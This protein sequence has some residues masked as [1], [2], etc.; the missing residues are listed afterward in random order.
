M[1]S[2]YVTSNILEVHKLESHPSPHK[3]VQIINYS[4]LLAI[5]KTLL[6]VR[7]TTQLIVAHARIMNY[8]VCP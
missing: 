5:P 6:S 4:Y 2:L 7:Y 3:I 1:N 8:N